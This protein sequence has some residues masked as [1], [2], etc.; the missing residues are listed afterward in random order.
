MSGAIPLLPPMCLHGVERDSITLTLLN[1]E[2]NNSFI[3]SCRFAGTYIEA[4]RLSF[5][6]H[7]F[8]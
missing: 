8:Q 4:T 5:V 1:A 6:I 7:V 3:H 2:N